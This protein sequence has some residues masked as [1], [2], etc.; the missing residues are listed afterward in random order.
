MKSQREET[1]K[2]RFG[3]KG[4]KVEGAV[5]ALFEAGEG[6]TVLGFG[7]F[8]DDGPV[9]EDVQ[10]LDGAA[11]SLEFLRTDPVAIEEGFFF[12]DAKV[13]KGDGKF[14]IGRPV[15]GGV[16]PID[17]GADFSFAVEHHVFQT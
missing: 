2:Q 11:H 17:D 8:F 16:F 5:E 6:G 9:V 3:L 10:D 7:S 1:T 13:V 14:P 4:K 15:A 12:I